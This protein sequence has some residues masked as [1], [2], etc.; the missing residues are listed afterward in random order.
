MAEFSSEKSEMSCVD[1][2]SNLLRVIAAP[3]PI[4]DSVK[5]A[6]TR[7]ARRVGLSPVRATGIW[8]REARAI[9]AAEMDAIRKAAAQRTQEQGAR[10]EYRQLVARLSVL[11]HRLA[12]IDPDFHSNDIAAHR[13]VLDGAG[14][15]D[16]PVDS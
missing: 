8:Y 10:N 2:A 6:I 3:R 15:K 4:G 16:R 12:T 1:E 5:A 13:E 9:R 11:E 7:A 14:G